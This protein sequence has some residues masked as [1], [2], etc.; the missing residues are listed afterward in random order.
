MSEASEC[1]AAKV[2]TLKGLRSNIN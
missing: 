1:G 2:S